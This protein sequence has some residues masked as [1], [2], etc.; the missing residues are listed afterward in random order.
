MLFGAS[1]G[2][3]FTLRIRGPASRSNTSGSNAS[4]SP[5]GQ[6]REGLRYVRGRPRLRR[7]VIVV[8]LSEVCFSGPVAAA[9]VLLVAERRWSG[10]MVG[11]ILGAF[12]VGGAVVGGFLAVVAVRVTVAT[13]V[14][15]CTLVLTACLLLVI[16]ATSPA[17][18]V[19]VAAAL[20]ATTGAAMVIGNAAIQTEAEP[21]F[22]GRVSSL[23]T[24][25]TLGLSPLL[26]PV[27]G[28]VAAVWGAETFFVVCAAVCAIAA[29]ISA[30]GTP[31]AEVGADACPT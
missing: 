9:V 5:W 26:Y 6:F 13:R 18:A 1:L 17:G 2:L 23:T 4:D 31:Q 24:L 29:V 3:L 8:G 25:C 30:L 19:C 20:G 15:A 14:M 27:V 7:L 11:W 21:R 12:S 16:G 22:L 10:A 28:I